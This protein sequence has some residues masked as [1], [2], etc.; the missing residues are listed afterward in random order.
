VHIVHQKSRIN[1]NNKE[2]QTPE[3][4]INPKNSHKSVDKGFLGSWSRKKKSSF[5][6]N[7][8]YESDVF[9]YY[10]LNLLIYKEKIK[11]VF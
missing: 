7:F 4:K 9:N 2:I 6:I 5:V 1:K 11:I 8:A 10:F 3:Y